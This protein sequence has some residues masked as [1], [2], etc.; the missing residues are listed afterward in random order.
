MGQ[1]LGTKLIDIK[2]C[3]VL[4][5]GLDNSGKSSIVN[6]M[7]MKHS[8]SVIGLRQLGRNR[9]SEKISVTPTIGFRVERVRV[10]SVNMT[11]IDMSGQGRYRNLWEYYYKECDAIVFVV[12]SSDRERLPVAYEEKTRMLLHPELVN[13]TIPIL[14]FSNKMDRAEALS[15]DELTHNLNRQ[16]QAGKKPWKVFCSIAKTGTGVAAGFE[17][18]ADLLAIEHSGHSE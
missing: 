13:R 9:I 1:K 14:Y 7:K 5:L 11:L 2:T 4:V 3:N 10:N 16:G 12:D 15:C 18:L 17:W 6:C 8:E